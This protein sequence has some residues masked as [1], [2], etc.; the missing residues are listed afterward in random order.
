[1][2]RMS[3]PRGPIAVA[4][5]S[6]PRSASATTLISP[7]LPGPWIQPREVTDAFWMPVRTLIPFLRACSSVIPAAPTSGSVNVTRGF[8]R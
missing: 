3:P 4:P 2:P 8:A 6:M 5:T 1:M 7:S